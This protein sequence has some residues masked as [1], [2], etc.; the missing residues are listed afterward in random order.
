MDW[1]PWTV[2]LPFSANN[3]S[4]FVEK[5]ESSSLSNCKVY[6]SQYT[7]V[8][9]GSDRVSLPAVNV[10]APTDLTL[11]NVPGNRPIKANRMASRVLFSRCL[12]DT[13]CG[14]AFQTKIK[15]TFPRYLVLR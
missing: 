14:C 9:T 6:I 1:L 3:E 5:T 12:E 13:V 2:L 11:I 8:N 15:T 7:L 10:I 4:F